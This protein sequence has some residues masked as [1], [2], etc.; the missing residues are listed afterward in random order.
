MIARVKIPI[1]F[2]LFIPEG[3]ILDP[4]VYIFEDLQITIYFPN[5]DDNTPVKSDINSFFIDKKK[6]FQV[7]KLVIDFKKEMFDRR[8]TTDFDPPVEFIQKI[9]SDFLLKLK[10]VIKGFQIKNIDITTNGISLLY[11]NDDGSNFEPSE[12]FVRGRFIK[13]IHYSWIA[14]NNEYWN[15]LRSL[16]FEFEPPN[17]Y[18]L[19]L[20]A[21]EALPNVGVSISYVSI[22]LEIFISQ[23]LEKL[24]LE[25]PDSLDLWNWV[26]NRDYL[27]SISVDEQ[28]SDLLNIYLGFSLKDNKNLWDAHKEIRHA[29][30]SFVHEGIA[31]FNF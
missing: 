21:L 8:I 6:S 26:N 4:I 19:Y 20:D 16:K 22:A 29:R 1:P 12:G 11:L 2:S 25:N 14:L 15:D 13:P 27:K 5:N 10:F 30:N 28:F 7:T 31:K 9:V 3:D 18:I 17:W 24:A 23:I